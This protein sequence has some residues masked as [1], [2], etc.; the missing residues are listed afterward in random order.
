[1]PSRRALV[2]GVA[3]GQV[4]GTVA[5]PL[6]LHVSAR[7]AERDAEEFVYDPTQLANALRDLADAVDPDG[8]PV[9]DAGVLLADCQTVADIVA[10]EQLTAAVEATR[11]LRTSF[12]DAIAL[13]AVLPGPAAI[14][15][16]AGA[17]TASADAVLALGKEFLAAGADV[18][19]VQDEDELPGAALT[20]LANVARFHQAAALSHGT[21]RYGLTATAPVDLHAPAHVA[22][23]AVTPGSLA[24]DTDLSVLRDWVTA[25][26]G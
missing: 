16:V 19:I 15:R 5:V 8:V 17:G 9:C 12:G 26:R 2:R 23:V 21:E 7:I 13:V 14:A 25:V 10:S 22:G 3:A 4:P 24:R 11:R 20:T 18:L 6:A 1:M